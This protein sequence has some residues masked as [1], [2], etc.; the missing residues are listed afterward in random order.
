MVRMTG[1]ARVWQPLCLCEECGHGE[2]YHRKKTSCFEGKR[3]ALR[4]ELVLQLRPDV[5]PT[6]IKYISLW[7]Q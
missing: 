3:L 7:R 1:I 5:Q 2:E 4:I 6:E